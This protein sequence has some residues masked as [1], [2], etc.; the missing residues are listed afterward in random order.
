M[1]LTRVELLC[2]LILITASLLLVGRINS[3]K[4]PVVLGGLEP[5]A[6]ML[7]VHPPP[8]KVK[9]FHETAMPRNTSASLP[10]IDPTEEKLN[11]LGLS[12]VGGSTMN[13]SG[14]STNT[15]AT[16]ASLPVH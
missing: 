1:N 3:P 9:D 15:S 2:I 6:E 12:L 7:I 16:T 5:S 10:E 8:P 11:K 14:L 4:K 13:L